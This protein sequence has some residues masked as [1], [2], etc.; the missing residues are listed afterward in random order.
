[1]EGAR[2]GENCKINCHCFIENDVVIVDNVSAKSGIYLWNG[3]RIG[4]DV[5]IG[6]KVTFINDKFSRSKQYP[7]EFL[8]T[9]KEEGASIGAGA[10]IMVLVK[11]Q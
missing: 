5:F 2:I 3:L 10:M 6:P 4:D 9:K 1:M 11:I 7:D 8:T